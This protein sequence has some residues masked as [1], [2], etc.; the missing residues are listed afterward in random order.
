[1]VFWLNITM[2]ANVTA[3]KVTCW[4]VGPMMNIFGVNT[5][6]IHLPILQKI[7]NF[8]WTN[9]VDIFL[10]IDIHIYIYIYVSKWVVVPPPR[11]YHTKSCFN[12]HWIKLI[13]KFI[14]FSS[15]WDLFFEVWVRPRSEDFGR[16]NWDDDLSHL[17]I[18]NPPTT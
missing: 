1:M 2:I 4:W 11:R 8:F 16:W 13:S 3:W 9:H 17:D 15:C 12:G 7:V 14:A 6:I 5:W 10:I 18:Q